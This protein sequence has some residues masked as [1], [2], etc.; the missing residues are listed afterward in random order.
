MVASKAYDIIWPTWIENKG[1]TEMLMRS[2][3]QQFDAQCAS[4]SFFDDKYE[5]F[6]GASWFKED[7]TPRKSSIAAHAL[8]S[9]DVFVI[10]DTEKVSLSCFHDSTL[11]ISA[12]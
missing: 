7:R 3:M 10:L 11:L 6:R 2:A 9:V 8:L 4:M 5:L 12:Y 1:P